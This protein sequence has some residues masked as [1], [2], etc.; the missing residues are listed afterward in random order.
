MGDN[1]FGPHVIRRLQAFY[2]FDPAVRVSEARGFG[3]DWLP[4]I[5]G[6]RALI[7]VDTLPSGREPGVLQTCRH[8]EIPMGIGQKGSPCELGLREALQLLELSGKA[9]ASVLLVTV[10]RGE[11]TTG[12]SMSPE[13]EASIP[14]AESEIV[15]ELSRLG[16]PPLRT[17]APPAPALPL[18]TP[19]PN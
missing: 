16:H 8:N 9:I 7:V 6:S 4:R 15:S 5:A 2:R 10:T 19:T 11:A 12:L 3:L 1:A 14:L 18:E 13:V 17:W